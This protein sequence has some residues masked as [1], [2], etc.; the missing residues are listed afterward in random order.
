MCLRDSLLAVFGRGYDGN[1]KVFVYQNSVSS[2]SNS[3]VQ[4]LTASDGAI[5]DYFGADV[6]ISGDIVLIGANQRGMSIP[7]PGGFKRGKAYSF[8]KNSLG[9]WEEEHILYHPWG[10]WDHLQFGSAVALDGSVAMIGH[11]TNWAQV[12]VFDRNFGEWKFQQTIEAPSNSWDHWSFGKSIDINGD[13][14]LV[15][16]ESGEVTLFERSRFGSWNIVQVIQSIGWHYSSRLGRNVALGS[17]VFLVGT[18][19][20]QSQEGSVQVFDTYSPDY[21]SRMIFCLLFYICCKRPLTALSETLFLLDWTRDS[22]ICVQ[23]NILSQ[24]S[25]VR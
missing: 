9:T 11:N 18:D 10:G 4:E 22:R 6:A 3:N 17:D 16:G 19:N 1:G 20:G 12:S 8:A 5:G 15:G 13:M 24:L 14:A 21:V 7:T 2:W 25:Y 23:W